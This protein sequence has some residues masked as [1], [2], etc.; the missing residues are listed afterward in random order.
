MSKPEHSPDTRAE[1]VQVSAGFRKMDLAGAGRHVFLCVGP[2]CC[3]PENGLAVW[4]VLKDRIKQSG[5]RSMRTKAAC[6]RICSGG[7]W[8]VVYPD[9]IWYGQLTPERCE[10]IIE[11]HLRQGVPV[12]E[13]IVRQHPLDGDDGSVG[14][15]VTL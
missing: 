4:E 14:K 6:F 12:T 1:N 15:K 3:S 8:M 10:R 7:P 2:D 13:W 5:I 11:Q 9:G